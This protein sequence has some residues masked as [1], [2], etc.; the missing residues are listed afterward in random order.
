MV[1]LGA[2]PALADHFGS[3]TGGVRLTVDKDWRVGGRDLSDTARINTNETMFTDYGPTNL[4][5]NWTGAATT[6]TT[7]NYDLCVY[8][9]DYGDTNWYGIYDCVGQSS[10]SHP[11]MTC[12]LGRVRLNQHTGPGY[13]AGVGISE[14][15]A[16]HEVGHSIGLN[17]NLDQTSCVKRFIDGGNAPTLSN[18]DVEEINAHYK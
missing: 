14:Y 17:H 5:V 16:C 8:D 2:T 6:C 13:V 11:N 7:T 4:N 3:N 15:N 1:V 10:G 9:S 12:T 18:H